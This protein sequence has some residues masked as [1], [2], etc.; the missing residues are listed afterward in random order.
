MTSI[1]AAAF[2][3]HAVG[4]TPDGTRKSRMPDPLSRL[5]VFHV[6]GSGPHCSIRRARSAAPVLPS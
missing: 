4:S 3:G 2:D 1:E 5:V 6:A